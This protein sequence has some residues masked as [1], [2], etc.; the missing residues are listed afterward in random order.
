MTG[1]QSP[2]ETEDFSS[3][4]YIRTGSGAYPA[5]CTVGTMGKA[6]PGRDADHSPP[7]SAKV[8]NEKELYLL[9]PQVPLWRVVGSL[10]FS[11]LFYLHG[12]L[13]S[14]EP[15]PLCASYFT[16][17]LSQKCIMEELWSASSQ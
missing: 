14:L 6:W 9:S 10:Y 3:S 16:H 13:S 2:T 8:K 4:L 11:E 17:Y 5:F 15:L 12:Q 7:S 1:V